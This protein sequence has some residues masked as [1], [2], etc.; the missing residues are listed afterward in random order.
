MWGC[1]WETI[2]KAENHVRQILQLRWEHC[3]EK[4][5]ERHQP[6]GAGPEGERSDEQARERVAGEVEEGEEAAEEDPEAEGTA[7]PRAEEDGQIHDAE[8]AHLQ[9]QLLHPAPKNNFASLLVFLV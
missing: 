8:S 3:R 7:G 9:D 5:K 4:K 1:R 6:V 2:P